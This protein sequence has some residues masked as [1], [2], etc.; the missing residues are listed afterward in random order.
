MAT[1]AENRMANE[2]LF[3]QLGTPGME[4]QAED[5]LNRYTKTTMRET[6]VLRKIIPLQKLTNDQLDRQYDTPIP[7]KVFDKEMGMP[8]AISVP[9]NDQPINYYI[10][11][12][13]Y[14]VTPSR[15][16]SPRFTVDVDELRTWEMDIRQVISDNALKDMMTEEDQKFFTAVNSALLGQD[17]VIPSAGG[18]ALWQGI[19]GGIDRDTW[20]D[21][22][23][24]MKKTSFALSPHTVVINFVTIHELMKQGRDEMGGDYAQ[25]IA[26]KG[27]ASTEYMGTNL[28]VTIKR[29]LVPDNTIFLFADPDFIGKHCAIED[30]T[31]YIK[32]E[33]FMLE[34]FAYQTTGCTIA[35]IG[36]IARVDFGV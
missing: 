16:L 17:T 26:K 19:S 21:A 5:T 8:A 36:G 29:S 12:P 31:M 4:K 33:A 20:N 1:L 14:R 6:G 7:A 22:L 25:D 18:V 34:F 32:R 23:T 30:T 28:I 2:I 35:H 24:V 11:G 27:W 9:L 3:D 10:E 15:T 13:R